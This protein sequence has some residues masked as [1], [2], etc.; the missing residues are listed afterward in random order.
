MALLQLKRL[1]STDQRGLRQALIQLHQRQMRV[2]VRRL[3][4]KI[5]GPLQKVMRHA[6]PLESVV[7]ISLLCQQA[8]VFSPIPCRLL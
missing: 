7:V 2:Y 8:P 5:N 1:P 6:K 3:Y 4:P